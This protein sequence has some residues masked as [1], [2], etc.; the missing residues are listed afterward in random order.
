MKNRFLN[1]IANL[2]EQGDEAC[3]FPVALLLR[4]H[5]HSPQVVVFTPDHNPPAEYCGAKVRRA[6]SAA[7]APRR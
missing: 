2:T 3:S 4:S 5:T 6:P 7:G 1:M